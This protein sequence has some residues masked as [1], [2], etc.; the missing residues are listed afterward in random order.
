MGALTSLTI[1]TVMASQSTPKT[2]MMIMVQISKVIL[3]NWEK[4]YPEVPR[5][6]MTSMV[7]RA[8]KAAKMM[9]SMILTMK[10]NKISMA[11]MQTK[12]PKTE[13]LYLEKKDVG[14]DVIT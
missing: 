4:L 2:T 12:G 13:Y 3:M 10:K 6:S 1:R 5:L 7:M 11:R 8:S 9:S 14:L